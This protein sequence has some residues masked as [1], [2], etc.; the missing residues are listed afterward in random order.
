MTY[1]VSSGTLNLD[2]SLNNANTIE[3]NNIIKIAPVFLA[4]KVISM[5]V[6]TYQCLIFLL[7]HFYRTMLC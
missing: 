4:V 5:K 1:F 3:V 6:T 2:Q 7:Q